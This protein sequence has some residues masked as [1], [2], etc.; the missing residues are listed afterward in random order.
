MTPEDI[1]K[2]YAGARITRLVNR[3]EILEEIGDAVRDT[4]GQT[5]IFYIEAPGGTG[6]TFLARDVLR[7]CREGEW[8]APDL[9]AAKDEVDLYHHQTHSWEG[10]MEAVAKVLADGAASFEAYEEQRQRLEEVKFDLR[11]AV[12]E[13]RRQRR[14]L[15]EAF[16][17]GCEELGRK[18][19]IVLVLDTAEK[20]VYE[21]DR[22]QQGLALSEE[23]FSMR[24]WLLD[25]WL[26]KMRNTVILI[27]GRSSRFG[28]DLQEALEGHAGIRFRT[29]TLGNFS[30]K[31]TLEY[32]EA[33]QETAKRDGNEQALE[34]LNA[35]SEEA[36]QVIHRLTEGHPITLA[37]M[38]DY[39]LVT[40]RLVSEVKMSLGEIRGKS[41]DELLEVRDKVERAVVRQFQELDRPGDEAIHAL[42][43][44]PKGMDAE[45]L[46][47]VAGL[48][49]EEAA[50]VI[51][52][53]TDPNA[54]LSFVK[55]R[56]ADQRVFLQDEMYALMRNHVLEKL[57]EARAD[58]VYEEILDYYSEKI[59]AARKKLYELSRLERAEVSAE[60][61]VVIDAAP[62]PPRDPEALVDAETHLH[63]MQVELLHY[64][65]RYRPQIGF[66]VYREYAEEAFQARDF[67]LDMR[68]RDELLWFT[69]KVF[70]S[71]QD[72]FRG[73]ER[74]DVE[75]EVA[76]QWVRR[77]V[78][79][80]D[81]ALAVGMA[82]QLRSE[83][84]DLLAAGGALAEAELKVWAG[85]AAAFL[86][87]DLDE[88]E[89]GLRDAVQLLTRVQPETG[90]DAKRR[91]TILARAYNGLGYL[92]RVKGEFRAASDA[93]RR[94][95]PLW[96]GLEREVEHA[97]SLNNLAWATAEIGNF[98][99]ALRYCEDALELREEL[100]SRYL[101]G[102]SFNTLGLIAIKNDQPHRGRVHC[103]RALAIFR[104]LRSSRGIGLAYTALAEAHRRGAGTPRVYFPA[105]KAKRLRL[106]EDFAGQ[107]VQIFRDEVPERLRLIEALIELGCDYRDWAR[108]RPE[109]Y[110]EGDPDRV[111]LAK[112]GFEALGEAAELAADEFQYR[113]VDALVNLAWLHFYIEEPKQAVAVLDRTDEI[114]P[115]DYL[116]VE[117]EGIPRSEGLH[118]FVWTQLGKAHLLRGQIALQRYWNEPPAEGGVRDEELLYEVARHFTL[119]LA[120]SE[121]FAEDYRGMRGAKDAMYQALKGVNVQE[122]DALYEDV[123]QI[124]E[125]Y[126][127]EQ[128]VRR[129][130][131]P[132]R[133]RMRN[134]LE[135]YFGPP[136]EYEVSGV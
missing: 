91:E 1:V 33:V 7:R 63:D 124:A 58:E 68:L 93:Y 82:R 121:L 21:T 18:K 17:R 126:G 64:S 119:T 2:A 3:D 29:P 110:D 128:R 101:V 44:A 69:H 133:P 88:A 55:I 51:E 112:R 39:Y 97:D 8:T 61:R 46:A 102:L 113:Q 81:Y 123:D 47:R 131:R 49:E 130:G 40:G 129:D 34:R 89:V 35:I 115:D 54:G 36:R 53:L 14:I 87:K 78:Y 114:V 15:S 26:P 103:E 79:S 107:A 12:S 66:E 31:D 127:L 125:R 72:A 28:E 42:S 45:L 57:P 4:S 104:D 94:S 56:P 74:C 10:F 30:E 135:Q 122:L 105:E 95:L 6:K 86:G 73:L 37:L 13:L 118:A 50:R 92:L 27:G 32:F 106:A 77:F 117:G 22:V 59:E 136:Q 25:A 109:Y 76:I 19:R 67:D 120:Y 60:G 38:I 52:A 80:T 24:P 48:S 84:A 20:L 111:E 100:G 96:R 98:E 132:A 71:G 70:E 83:C 9:L 23:R 65:I 75:W 108:L 16:V 41:S 134:F 11:G 90:A 116:I 85:W 5:Y 99:R 62:G 43:W